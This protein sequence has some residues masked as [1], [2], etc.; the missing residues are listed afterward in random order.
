MHEF[1]GKDYGVPLIVTGGTGLDP[2][3]QQRPKK[4]E[5]ILLEYVASLYYKIYFDELRPKIRVAMSA[6]FFLQRREQRE[7]DIQDELLIKEV[8]RYQNLLSQFMKYR[9]VRLEQVIS[10]QKLGSVDAL[11]YQETKS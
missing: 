11:P 10:D 8:N 6:W 2:A 5:E 9:K 4:V 3:W 7:S 1:I